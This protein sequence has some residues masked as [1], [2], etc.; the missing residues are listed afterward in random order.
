MQPPPRRETTA[1]PP[2]SH[3]RGRGARR[4]PPRGALRGG[5]AAPP[6]LGRRD[7]GQKEE[8]GGDETDGATLQQ[9][10]PLGHP[11]RWIHATRVWRSAT[12]D[13]TR[14]LLSLLRLGG[15]PVSGPSPG[16]RALQS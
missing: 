12:L 13:V 10:A 4:R 9:A 6:L 11:K 2:G 15:G 16:L 5:S 8:W 3:G 1:T 14:V 7:E